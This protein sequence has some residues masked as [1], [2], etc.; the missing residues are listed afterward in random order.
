LVVVESEAKENPALARNVEALKAVQPRK[1]GIDEIHFTLGGSWIP[2]SVVTDWMKNTF[3]SNS[4]RAVIHKHESANVNDSWTISG[5]GTAEMREWRT[6]RVDTLKLIESALNL[7]R[8][9][10]RDAT[11]E[12]GKTVAN[13]EATLA[14]ADM[15]RKLD[16]NFQEWVRSNEKDR[17]YAG[18]VL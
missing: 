15:Q 13:P 10:V 14:A 17:G 2:A 8:V 9:Q 6:D 7:K 5:E 3:K 4:L 16:K 11:G 18:G 1:L 12:K